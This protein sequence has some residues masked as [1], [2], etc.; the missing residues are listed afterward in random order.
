MPSTSSPKLPRL[1]VYLDAG[2]ADALP[3]AKAATSLKRPA[4]AGTQGFF[5]NST[6]FDSTTGDRLRR[7]DLAPDR[8][9]HFVVNTAEERPGPAASPK[10]ASRPATRLLCNP[11][12]P[13]PRS[14][15]DR[16]HRLTATSTPTPGSPTPATR[17]GPCAPAHPPPVKFAR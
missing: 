11:P 4:F 6:H 3:A 13:R 16:Q 7:D 10:T 8:R 5:L 17:G 14:Q 1:V 9:K 12:G 15:A 2:A